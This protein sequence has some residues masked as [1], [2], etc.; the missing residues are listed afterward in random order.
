MT[1]RSSG[2]GRFGRVSPPLLPP[3]T[4]VPL[5][6]PFGLPHST[7]VLNQ[8]RPNLSISLYLEA[9]NM[10]TEISTHFPFR[11]LPREIRNKIYRELLCSFEPPLTTANITSAFETSFASCRHAI[12]T[13]ILQTNTTTYGEAYDVL[14][15]TNRFVRITSTRG[16]PLRSLMRSLMVPVVACEKRTVGSFKGYVLG[17]LLGLKKPISTQEH[18]NGEGMVEH[19]DVMILHRDLDVF[20]RALADADGHLAGLTASLQLLIRVAPV[21][22]DQRSTPHAPSFTDFFSEATQKTLLAPIRKHLRGFTSVQVAGRVESSLALATREE[23]QQD[24]WSD[25]QK[26]LSDFM[27]AKEAGTS[28]FQQRNLEMASLTWQDAALDIDKIT[29]SKSWP[30]LT[31]RG[32]EY[33][34][35]QLADLYFIVRLN[36]AHIQLTQ[37]TDNPDSAYFAG[38]LAQDALQCAMMSMQKDYWMK[39]F[40]YTPANKHWAKLRYRLAML[41]RLQGVPGTAGQA[42]KMVDAA[43]RLMPGDVGIMRERERIMA[44][45]AR[46]E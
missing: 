7:P 36:I 28:L 6:S 22:S 19:E 14:V 42:L 3:T 2:L 18:T 17:I 45:L 46:G 13:T 32:G 23:L 9:T 44:W 26:V 1:P 38:I 25:T 8:F 20:C 34:V 35:S 37:M 10:T 4:I 30:K 41:K 27:A 29:G 40:K 12:D 31:A 21:L 11:S 39:G 16:I 43:L 24:R 33:F 5:L 15:K